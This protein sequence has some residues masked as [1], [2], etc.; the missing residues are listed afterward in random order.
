MI[1]KKDDKLT[2]Q[3]LYNIKQPLVSVVIPV[4]N[5]EKYVEK[6]LDSIVNQTYKNIEIIIVNN[7]SNGNIQSIFDNYKEAYPLITFK[8]VIHK[9][10]QGLFKARISGA[11]A[12]GGDYITFTDSD[13]SISVDYYRLLIA[14]AMKH[15]SDMTA[16]NVIY[17]F[18]DGKKVYNNL[19]NLRVLSGKSI[20]TTDYL[21]M[22]YEGEGLYHT[23]HCVW[24]KLYHR[25]L[26]ER[27]KPYLKTVD[28][29]LVMCED[30]VF[31]TVFYALAKKMF[32]TED[33]HYYYF[34][35]D[36]AYTSIKAS[37]DKFE[38]NIG[39]LKQAF[40]AIKRL[41]Q[42]LGRFDE[43]RKHY[44]KWMQ[45]YIKYWFSNIKNSSLNS[46]DKMKMRR[47][48]TDLFQVSFIDE[49]LENDNFFNQHCTVFDDSLNSLKK[50]MLCD[51]C[52]V[53]T[54]DIFDTLIQ[55][56]FWQPSD[57]FQLMDNKFLKYDVSSMI[58]FSDMR[59]SA[60]PIAR[61]KVF[62]QYSSYEEVTLDEIYEVIADLYSVPLDI[63]EEMKNMEI[64]LERRY[65]VTRNAGK[66]LFELAKYLG[67]EV[68]LISDMYLS[69]EIVQQILKKNGYQITDD[70]I[71]ISSEKRVTKHTGNLYKL[72]LSEYKVKY[73]LSVLHIGDNF[74]SD[75]QM[76]RQQ[77]I[78]PFVLPKA[79]DVFQNN[80]PYIYSGEH[81]SGTFKDICG[82]IRTESAN[83]FLGIRCMLAL[84]ANNFFDNPFISFSPDSDYNAN[85]QFIGYY[86]MGMYLF[87][88]A[89]W[90]ME[91]ING[92]YKNIQFIARDG[93]LVK[94]AFEK[95]GELFDNI[96]STGYLY[97]SRKAL[98]PL[99][100]GKKEFIHALESVVASSSASPQKI[101]KLLSPLMT[102]QNENSLKEQCEDNHILYSK[103]FSTSQE[104]HDFLN[105]WSDKYYDQN[106]VDKYRETQKRYFNTVL[107]NDACTFDLG[108][109][110]RTETI[111][112]DVTGKIIDAFYIHYNSDRALNISK[113][114]GFKVKS[115]YDFCPVVT[116]TMRELLMSEYA[117]SCIGYQMDK[118]NGV[119]PVFEEFE[120]QYT[121]KFIINL[122]QNSA[123]EFVYDMVDTFGEDLSHMP[124]Q[125]EVACLP[126]EYFL[127]RSK[128][129][130]RTILSSFVF[131]D[132]LYL[133]KKTKALDFWNMQTASCQ[134][135]M[136]QLTSVGTPLFYAP[137]W[138][139]AIYYFLFDRKAF[140][141][142]ATKKLQKHPIILKIAQYGY[143]SC[144]KI[145]R[146]IKE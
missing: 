65:C 59:K 37:K 13:D 132:D 104:F 47:L 136:M 116:G 1:K 89:Q 101:F 30:M 24:N 144:R 85:P 70:K 18:P 117:P 68:F 77:G 120:V 38:K 81:Y 58:K 35:G 36:D 115:L 74:H 19:D 44:D 97:T 92:K 91:N 99:I 98:T 127:N 69:K 141:E 84:I 53:V 41:L 39:D 23:M 50:A 29:H 128:Q 75:Y 143:R 4:Y 22:L 51:N 108:Y 34:K 52:K 61:K 55:R 107:G 17:E 114:N 9:E 124:F 7:N 71:Y 40:D 31:S 86:T 78:A 67:K 83:N 2:Q 146:M 33:T 118:T 48:L 76:A 96:P 135:N 66:R 73:A 27:A 121:D 80:V 3:S 62:S 111:L 6:C 103:T 45:L 11:E 140:K 134:G 122:I 142:K 43:L 25:S 56:P 32:V 123:L 93:F 145:Y 90:L 21:N 54:F 26:W 105:F 133:G 95:Y 87:T 12:A 72:F 138:K 119:A 102:P 137:V 131:E 63:I 94:K 10:N 109:S 110:G 100:V 46:V 28:T 130:D 8:L 113:S 5:T 88:I 60:E 16:A 49:L 42:D 20:P 112:H 15:N 129:F 125:Y 106:I 57:M 139:K 79:T 126:F 14:D 64:D 82:N